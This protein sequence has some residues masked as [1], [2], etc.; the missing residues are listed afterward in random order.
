MYLLLLAFL[1][2]LGGHVF[3]EYT[4]Q[5]TQLGTYKRKNLLGLLIHA[6]L[7]SLAMCPGLGLLNLFAPWKALF[8]FGTHAIIDLLKM[9]IT[10]S[11]LKSF[12]PVNL[13]DQLLHFLTLVFVYLK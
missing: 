9:S 13:I 2:T 10:T 4:L 6:A 1:A 11:K 5:K 3:T 8:L 7:W 12:H